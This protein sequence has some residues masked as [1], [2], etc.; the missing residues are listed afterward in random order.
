[1]NFAIPSSLSH[2]VLK[3]PLLKSTL[4]QVGTPEIHQSTL[5]LQCEAFQVVKW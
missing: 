5:N 2:R 1:M 4:Q 3:L